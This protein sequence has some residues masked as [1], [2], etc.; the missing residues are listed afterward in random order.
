MADTGAKP[1]LG[2][3][4]GCGIPPTSP[5]ATTRLPGAGLAT[6]AGGEQ[7]CCPRGAAWSGDA[8][9][10]GCH[11]APSEQELSVPATPSPDVGRTL[12]SPV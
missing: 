11:T 1:R 9:T 12:K 8:R 6:P 3:W 10:T 5:R 2:G 7:G 4:A